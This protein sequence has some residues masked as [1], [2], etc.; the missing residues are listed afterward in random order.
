M[1]V[2]AIVYISLYHIHFN[3]ALTSKTNNFDHVFSQNLCMKL[4]LNPQFL[5]MA[6]VMCLIVEL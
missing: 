3:T 5:K 2:T 4:A 1:A 6:K